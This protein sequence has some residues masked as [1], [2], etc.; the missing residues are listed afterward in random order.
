MKTF[1][2]GSIVVACLGLAA[3][4]H[5]G[6]GVS[7]NGRELN[8]R[9]F[10][11]KQLNGKQLNEGSPKAAEDQSLPFESFKVDCMQAKAGKLINTCKR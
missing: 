9:Q 4:A 3:V 6:T 5:A 2:Q 7:P 1:I 10:N 8:G 11:G